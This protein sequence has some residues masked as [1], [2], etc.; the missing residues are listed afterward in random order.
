VS[1]N[2]AFAQMMRLSQEGDKKAYQ[3]LLTQLVPLLKGYVSKR[4]ADEGAREDLV[5]EILISVDH[6]KHTYDASRAFK[7]WLFSIAKYRLYDYLRKHYKK[8]EKEELLLQ[9]FS[10]EATV[11]IESYVT[12]TDETIKLLETL[13]KKQQ[14]ILRL[15]KVEGYSA[16]ETAKKCGMSEGAVKVTVHRSLK[17]LK[18][19]YEQ[20]ND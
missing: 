14:V 5:Q 13:P 11:D 12:M 15:M 1:D 17:Q 19:K 20:L 6:A 10:S 8:H 2:D 4:I 18:E 9:E 3:R 7:P 16:A